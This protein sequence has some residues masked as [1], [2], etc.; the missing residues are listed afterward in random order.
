MEKTLGDFVVALRKADLEVS[1][2][3]T[4]D[5]MYALELI[6]LEDRRLLRDTLS[7]ILAK[8]PE[9][10]AQFNVC[11]ERFFSFRAFQQT[12]KQ[13]WQA[14]T[15]PETG[16]SG[17]P[18]EEHAEETAEER[19]SRGKR[20]RDRASAHH[21]SRLGH[22]LLTGEEAELALLMTNAAKAVKLENIKT[23]RER[24][25]YAKRILVHMS[26]P[27]LEAEIDR[28]NHQEDDRSKTTAAMLAQ[29]RNYLTEQVRDFVESQYLLIVD[30]TGDRFL[31][32]AVSQTKLTNM[33]VYYFDHIRQAVRKLANQL[34]KRHA[35]RKKLTNRG[36]LDVRKTLRKNLQFDGMLFDIQWKQIR[37]ERPKVFVLCDVSGSVKNVSRFLLTFLYS[38]NEVL[39]KVRAFAFSNDLGEVTELFDRYGLDEAIEMSLDDYG[40]GSTDYGRAFN[41]FKE[42][43]LSDVDNRSTVII[44]GDGRNNYFATGSDALKQI[45]GRAR[46]VIWLNPEPRDRWREGDAEMKAYLPHCDHAEVCNSLDD[47]E[48]M[49]SRVLRSAQ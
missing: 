25:L 15:G 27:L 40:K 48:R 13:P 44:L 21:N 35:K 12:G 30:G 36:H 42:I 16:G 41:R 3:E 11:F 33:Q 29:A 14:S 10:K 4:L 26:M 28:L 1:P 7:I 5:A 9:E 32:D 8:T 18:S 6:G 22:L 34:A 23:L 47:L 17:L 45:S 46:Q 38:L 24:S 37:L 39:P 31:A 49:V 19:S 43:A 20:R 2:A